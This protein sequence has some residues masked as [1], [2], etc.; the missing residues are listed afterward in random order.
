MSPFYA[1]RSTQQ[2]YVY[3]LDA[4]G[5]IIWDCWV[6]YSMGYSETINGHFH[7]NRPAPDSILEPPYMT[8]SGCLMSITSTKVGRAELIYWTPHPRINCVMSEYTHWVGF[9]DICW[10][11]Q[12]PGWRHVGG[13][14]TGHGGNEYNH[15]MT[16]SAA[17]GIYYTILDFQARYPAQTKVCVNDMALPI[18][19]KFDIYR[20]WDSPHHWH[21]RGMA[22][23][24][25][26]TDSNACGSQEA[27][28]IPLHL[29][30]E[31]RQHCIARG[32]DPSRSIL[33][34]RNVHCNWPDPFTPRGG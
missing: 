23:D 34:P 16:V 15:W 21:D 3:C 9:A 10:V 33:E 8:C 7:S 31:F 22:V 32:A 1:P 20:N 24:I 12:K 5:R 30:E 2:F 18:G 4:W 25:N 13:N 28:G 27:G 14:T 6:S 26:T 11:E 17:Y 29:R 19:G